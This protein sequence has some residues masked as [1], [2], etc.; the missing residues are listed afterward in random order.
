[1]TIATAA[2]NVLIFICY[3]S[4][5]LVRTLIYRGMYYEEDSLSSYEMECV[6]C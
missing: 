6:Y 2:E 1:M 5:Q 4:V 3:S